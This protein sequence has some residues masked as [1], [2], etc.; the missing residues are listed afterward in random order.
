MLASGQVTR[1]TLCTVEGHGIGWVPIWKYLGREPRRDAPD[2]EATATEERSGGS[3]RDDPATEKQKAKLR[4]FGC[5]WDEGITKGQASDALTECAKQFPEVEEA[6]QNQPASAEQIKHL[7]ALKG[8]FEPGITRGEARELI[9][10]IEASEG[11]LEQQEIEYL[12]SRDG[13]I[14]EYTERV[15]FDWAQDYREVTREEVASAFDCLDQHKPEWDS[16][17]DIVNA[18]EAILPDFKRRPGK[19]GISTSYCLHCRGAIEVSVPDIGRKITS[20][21]IISVPVQCPHCG[22]M[23]DV[24]GLRS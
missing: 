6:W 24:I 23:T 17:A 21:D 19:R 11:T 12:S 15:N 9:E 2:E 4:F 1:E 20:E 16:A 18:L 13:K 10:E 5:S 22:R 3:W 14:D 8:D 7:E